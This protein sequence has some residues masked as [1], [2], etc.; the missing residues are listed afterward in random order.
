MK[1]IFKQLGY[2]VSTEETSVH[3]HKLEYLIINNPN[4]SVRWAW[5]LHTKKPLFLKFYSISSAKAFVFAVIIK[6]I[7]IL[8]IQKLFFK[9]KVL[10]L[11]KANSDLPTKFNLNCQW[12]LFT[13]TA[14]PNQKA[15]FCIQDQYTRSFLKVALTERSADL[16]HREAMILN[17]LYQS[18]IQT[19]D[20]PEVLNI[21]TRTLEISDIKGSGRRTT[22]LS[23]NH[24]NAFIE[25]NELS[26]IQ[27]KLSENHH[28]QNMKGDM[29]SLLT[30]EDKRMPKG[31]IRKMLQMIDKTN[32]DDIIEVGLSHGDFTPWN[33]YES[34]QKLAI[35]DWELA[36]FFKPLGYDVFHYIV[37]HN[38]MLEHKSWTEIKRDIINTI[39]CDSFAA[40]SKF[41]IKQRQ[42]YLKLYFLFHISYYL[43]L[44]TAQAVWHPQIYWQINVWNEALSSFLNKKETSRELVL[45]DVFDFLLPFNYG[46]IKFKNM[47]PE[48]LSEY[49][50][51]D[52]C[53]EK[54]VS[55][56]LVKFLENHPLT[57]R[58]KTHFKSHMLTV[59]TFI[60]NG[61]ILSIDAIWKVKR[62]A[63]QILDTKQLLKNAYTNYYGVKTLDVK[64]NARYIALF[65]TLNNAKIPA[66]YNYFEELLNQSDHHLD[67]YLYDSY[68]DESPSPA[69]LDRFIKKQSLNRGLKGII[70]KVQYA[71]DS[72]SA[73]FNNPGIVV[74]F[75]GVDGAGKSTV[76]QNLSYRIEKQLRKK[77]VVL[78]HRPSLLPILSAWTK[79]KAQAE[80]DAAS[81]LPRQGQNKNLWSSFLRFSYYYVD[82]LIGQF[83]V[84]IKYVWRGYVVIYDRYYYDF[85][86]DSKRSNITIPSFIS[87]AGFMFLMKPKF[88]FFLYASPET[89]L[90]RKKELDTNSI[91]DLTERYKT[92][93][94]KL[95]HS[96]ISSN[97][98][99]IQNTNLS[100]TLQ[101]VFGNIAL[102]AC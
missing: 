10:F 16:I 87:K 95:E 3:Q 6:L 63:L 41:S 48:K 26:S 75:S 42:K 101:T 25:L 27:M 65:Y 67:K 1:R 11:N 82:Y 90:S 23:A 18:N 88:N 43:K 83:V 29:E 17:R 61:S 45:M 96:S 13:G 19:F 20:F 30:I 40:L 85:M 98:I 57:H 31:L 37:Q 2:Q 81:Q 34:N 86:N 69:A 59:H 4:G 71:L 39:N 89:I 7:F 68:L 9:R 80:Q 15:V 70:N 47:Y 79:G 58:T 50:D 76:I 97:Y 22:K 21:T 5:P 66:K 54:K 36:D 24:I 92:Q 93:F 74:T 94:N 8:R 72:A 35:Y 33:M 64:D 99:C 52:M 77:V 55:K 28:W 62:K 12:A 14:G 56:E 60:R 102:Q 38:I 73:P 49:S 53:V 84:N 32:E 51:I 44:Y 100:D 78:R 46:T 91:I